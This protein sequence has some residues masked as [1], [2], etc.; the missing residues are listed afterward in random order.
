M[1]KIAI[2]AGHGLYTY[3]KR[4]L[5]KLDG[6]ETR[7]WVLNDRISDYLEAYLEGAGHTVLRVDDTDGSSD[8]SLA[9]RVKKAN[10]WKADAY[11]SVHHNAGVNGGSGGGTVVYVAKSCSSKSVSLQN[12][13]YKYAIMRANL[14]GNR[15]DGTL[16]SNFYVI[17]NTNMPA[18]LIEAGFMDSSTDIRYILDP[19]WSKKMA[20]GI[21]EGICEVFGGKVNGG[22]NVA[23]VTPSEAKP[24]QPA[25]KPAA[26]ITSSS[27]ISVDGEWG[28]DTTKATQKVLGT[29]VDG[30]VSKQSTSLKVYLPNV[31]TS[32]WQF[33]KSG[34]KGGSSMVKAIQKLVGVSQDGLCGKNTVK[35]MQ[36]F[37]NTK[38]YNCG[39]VDGVMGKNTVM[40][41]QKYI[42]SR[43]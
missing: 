26:P 37:L 28:K 29:P 41:W 35:A 17:R 11:I 12:A 36:R 8:I 33:K 30:I 18:I 15:S 22:T 16:A 2:D 9:N 1:A 39:A 38:G 34:F 23:P 14:R 25:I 7:E 3:G 31:L 10:N 21:A 43:L 13:V 27:K 40:A 19:A 20:L 4:C 24:I 6:N 5:K 32:S 42:N